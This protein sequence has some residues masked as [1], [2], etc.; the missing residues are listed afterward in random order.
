MQVGHQN[1]TLF[2]SSQAAPRTLTCPHRP[3]QEHPPPQNQFRPRP[4]HLHS[5]QMMRLC[6]VIHESAIQT[7]LCRPS[8]CMTSGMRPCSKHLI[9]IAAGSRNAGKICCFNNFI[10][11]CS[12]WKGVEITSSQRGVEIFDIYQLGRLLL[13]NLASDTK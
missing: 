8:F 7:C 4:P 3:L 12:L 5:H 1:W 10:L 13:L 11:L 2:A 6:F 9:Y